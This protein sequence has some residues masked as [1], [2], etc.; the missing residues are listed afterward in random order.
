MYNISLSDT[1]GI[2]QMKQLFC[3][4]WSITQLSRLGEVGKPIFE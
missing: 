3:E 1:R 2:K 4:I